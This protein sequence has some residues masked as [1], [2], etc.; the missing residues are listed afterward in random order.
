[1]FLSTTQ[2]SLFRLFLAVINCE[3]Y[4]SRW[5]IVIATLSLEVATREL[6][7]CNDD[8]NISA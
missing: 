1:V 7:T 3:F 8:G 2:S 6:H 4:S 5:R